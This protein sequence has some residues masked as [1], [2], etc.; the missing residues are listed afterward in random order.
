[1]RRFIT[2]WMIALW[3]LSACGAYT[4]KNTQL[5]PP[6][7]AYDFT[8]TDQNNQSVTLSALRGNVV[9][10]FFGYTNCP[11]IC[12]ATLSDMQLLYNRLGDD[13]N[14]VRM[15]FVTVDPERDT[16]DKLKRFVERFD[17]RIIALSGETS[18]LNTMYAAYGAGATRRELA[19]S[20]LKYAMDHTS[21]MT[22]VDKQG[23]RRLLIGF[24]SNLDD[25]A[26]DIRAL[27]NE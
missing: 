16:S 13:G 14:H 1:M 12:P 4:Y 6:D 25:T 8:L 5:N 17:S 22:V 10:I 26:S 11:D 21:T 27:V 9:I 3:M 19:N 15:I 20:A 23:M 24:A 2:V 18:A 7:L